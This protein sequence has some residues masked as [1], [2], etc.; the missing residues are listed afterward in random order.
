MMMMMAV[1]GEDGA[2][3]ALS[4]T[5]NAYVD[6]LTRSWPLTWPLPQWIGLRG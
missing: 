3:H 4:F 2:G 5:K 6:R 1:A